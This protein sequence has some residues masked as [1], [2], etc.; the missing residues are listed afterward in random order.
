MIEEDGSEKW[1]FESFDY[2]KPLNS[3]DVFIFW[4]GQIANALFW[5]FILLIKL[6]TLS[7]FWVSLSGNSIGGGVRARLHQPLRVLQV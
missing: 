7:L 4:Y 2:E 3:L 1:M 5:S 6:L